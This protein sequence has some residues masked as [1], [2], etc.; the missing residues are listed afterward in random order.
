M[1]AP[2]IATISASRSAAAL[3]N[4]D[5]R[6]SQCEQRHPGAARLDHDHPL[7]PISEASNPDNTCLSHRRA[8]HPERL[9]RDRVIGIDVITGY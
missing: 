8:D 2:A 9:Y 6:G 7:A 4:C 1:I 3:P 5:A